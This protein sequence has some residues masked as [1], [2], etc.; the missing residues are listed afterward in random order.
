MSDDSKNAN[1]LKVRDDHDYIKLIWQ[2]NENQ[3]TIKSDQKLAWCADNV[4]TQSE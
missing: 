1:V 3:F 2:N 4:C